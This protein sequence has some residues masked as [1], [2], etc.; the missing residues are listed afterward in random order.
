MT[1][2]TVM[3]FVLLD[4]TVQAAMDKNPIM[5]HGRLPVFDGDTDS[6][7]GL[8]LR[9][10]I[11]RKAAANENDVLMSDLMRDII[12]VREHTN[13]DDLLDIFLMKKEQLALVHDEFGGTLGI[14]TMEDVIETILGVEI[15][16]EKDMEGIEEGVVGED[17][18]QFAKDKSNVDED[19]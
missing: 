17:M 11:Y 16:D 14:V 9:S 19:E 2:R 12:Q 8:V 5:V 18:R 1:P 3:S 15:V 7:K 6:P 4:D 13:L 10:E